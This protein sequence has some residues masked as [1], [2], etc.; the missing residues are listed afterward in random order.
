[1]QL[2]AIVKLAELWTWDWFAILTFEG[3]KSTADHRFDQGIAKVEQQVGGRQFR[4][5]RVTEHSSTAGIRFH[6]LVGGLVDSDREPGF[7]VWNAVGGK[8]EIKLFDPAQH[9]I[10]SMLKN[11]NKESLEMDCHFPKLNGEE[12]VV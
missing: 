11:L 7:Q 3:D 9:R 8:A 6:V 12:D 5:L 10:G 1:M 2:K 4:W